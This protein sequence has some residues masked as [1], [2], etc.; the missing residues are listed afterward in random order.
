MCPNM[1]YTCVT[2]YAIG[3]PYQKATQYIRMRHVTY[4]RMRHCTHRGCYQIG[5]ASTCSNYL[6]SIS[7][8]PFPAHIVCTLL[9]LLVFALSSSRTCWPLLL[10]LSLILLP[11]FLCLSAGGSVCMKPSEADS[12]CT[13]SFMRYLTILH[14][15]T[16]IYIYTYIY[17]HIYVYI[18]VCVYVCMCIHI[19]IFTWM[20]IY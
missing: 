10:L 5:V 17:I 3:L 2:S 16:Y 19:W 13:V 18:H 12:E 20:S 14:M 15:D 6:T 7:R 11:L 4:M 9:V 8:I 1:A